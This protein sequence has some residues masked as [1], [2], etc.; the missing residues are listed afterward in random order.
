MNTGHVISLL[1]ICYSPLFGFP[2]SLQDSF[3]I[4]AHY[5]SPWFLLDVFRDF[6]QSTL[7]F[8]FSPET[9]PGIFSRD[10]SGISSR[11]STKISAKNFS[12][13]SFRSSF[14]DFS[15]MFTLEFFSGVLEFY[16]SFSRDF[17][18]PAVAPGI[19][20]PEISYSGFSGIS[21]R[22]S[23]KLFVKTFLRAVVD[24]FGISAEAPPSISFGFFLGFPAVNWAMAE[25]GFPLWCFVMHGW[26]AVRSVTEQRSLVQRVIWIEKILRKLLEGC[27]NTLRIH[28]VIQWP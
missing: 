12:C 1:L 27:S 20:F 18:F 26:S 17:F 21:Q 28:A 23:S 16:K 24:P 6:F 8:G 11:V 7:F 13:N 5:F 14:H 10:S 25:H 4:W 9:F 19:F 22:V 15:F 3:E 2:C